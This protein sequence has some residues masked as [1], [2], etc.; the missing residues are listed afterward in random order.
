MYQHFS[1]SVSKSII[2]NM[3]PFINIHTHFAKPAENV[4]SIQNFSQN[5]WENGSYTEGGYLVSIGLH[6][7]FLTKENAEKDLKTLTELAHH[8]NVLAIGECGLDRLK[9][10]NLAFQTTLFEAQIHLAEAVQKPVIIHCVRAFN[11]VIVLKKKLKPTVPLIIHGFNKNATILAALLKNGFYI[12]IGEHILRGPDEFKKS[13]SDIP[14][15]KLFFETDDTDVDIERVYEAY[16]EWTGMK[17]D[18]LKSIVYDN[19][20]NIKN[21]QQPHK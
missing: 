21:G 2:T 6:P 1:V 15:D 10:E 3:I 19:F 9:G 17:I 11:E 7:W 8:P 20:K 14:L 5:E 12:S 13:V 18:V 16:S 4:L